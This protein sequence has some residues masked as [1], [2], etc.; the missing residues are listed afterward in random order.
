MKNYFVIISIMII[1]LVPLNASAGTDEMSLE[2]LLSYATFDRI[3][4]QNQPMFLHIL[5]Y[6]IQQW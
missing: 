3:E 6:M 2:W 4:D 5:R 1:F